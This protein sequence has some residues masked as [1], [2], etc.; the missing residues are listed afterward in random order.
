MLV[1]I[2]NFDESSL[3]EFLGNGISRRV[4]TNPFMENTV[5]KIEDVCKEVN[6]F[7]NVKEYLISEELKFSDISKYIAKC[8][9]ISNDG[10]YMIQELATDLTDEDKVLLKK[11][12]FPSFMTDCKDDN[13]GKT[14][15]GRIV[16]RDYGSSIITKNIR[17]CRIRLIK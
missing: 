8:H 3:T 7:Q 14:I 5:V 6:L 12:R 16:F 10:K 13:L 9:F 1:D 17:F 15:D 4:F 11:L 2:N